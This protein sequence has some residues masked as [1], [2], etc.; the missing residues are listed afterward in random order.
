MRIRRFAAAALGGLAISCQGPAAV[1]AQDPA[2][3]PAGSHPA[4]GLAHRRRALETLDRRLA[5]YVMAAR[6]PEIRTRLAARR[7]ALLEIGDPEAFR[8]ALNAELLSVSGDKHLQVWLEPRSR[9]DEIAA[10][11][12]PTMEDLAAAE[13]ANGWGVREAKVAENGVAWLDMASFSGH[14][15]SPAAIDAA[16]ARLAGARAL[17]I[18]VRRNGGGG[19]P[20]LRQLMGHLA[21]EPMRLEDIAFRRCAPDPVDP[22]GCVQDGG[23][24]VQVR[25]ASAVATPAFPTAPLYVLVGPE[26]F[27]AAEALAYDLQAIGRA[28]VIGE[29]TGGG[30]NPSIAMD[31]GPWFTV[32][33]PIGEARH[34]VTGTNWEGVGV[35]PDI[36]VPTAEAAEAALRQI[37]VVSS[38]VEAGDAVPPV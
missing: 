3:A 6:T 29:P 19:E 8:R 25:Y 23:R 30:A 18:D 16:M 24:E 37:G 21:P 15:D 32:I 34:P 26:T 2:A 36:L 31:L 28:T 4:S 33:M 20:A 12:P 22:E 9:D 27:S 35:Q 1:L 7:S 5:H 13:A 11:P 38:G 14:P 17:V 10:G